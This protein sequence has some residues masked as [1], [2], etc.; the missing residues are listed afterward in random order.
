[1]TKVEHPPIAIAIAIA[2]AIDIGLGAVLRAR[3]K[4]DV[5]T[6]RA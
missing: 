6:V 2:I 4:V 3:H 1:M 5:C